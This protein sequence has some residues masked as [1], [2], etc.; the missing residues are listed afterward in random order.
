[1][2]KNFSKKIKIK[3]DIILECVIINISK[4][5]QGSFQENIEEKRK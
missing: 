3:L 5:T 4:G 2:I 1:M